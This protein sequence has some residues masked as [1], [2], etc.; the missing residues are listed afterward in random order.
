MNV[1]RASLLSLTALA[2]L[3]LVACGGDDRPEA[4]T[5][6]VKQPTSDLQD[7]PKWILNPNYDEKYT[8]SA[9]GSARSTIG[10]LPQQ[11]TFAENDGRVKIAQGIETKVKS[12]VE[13]FY[14][15]GGEPGGAERADEV[16]RTISQSITNISASGIQRID[17]YRDK[18]DGTVWVWMVIDP[19]KQ[20]EIAGQIAKVASK[21]AADRAQTK[22]ELKADD[23]IQRLNK[24]IDDSLKQQDAAVSK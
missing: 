2:T 16:R 10:G 3:A 6:G 24:A 7:L 13:N 23:A 18:S 9:A 4:V 1:I 20:A 22:A 8:I 21:A 19:K 5:P 15:Q 17:L 12:L 11:I 14:S